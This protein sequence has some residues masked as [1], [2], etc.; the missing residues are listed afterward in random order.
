MCNRSMEA[1]LK[2]S[3]NGSRIDSDRRAKTMA[4]GRQLQLNVDIAHRQSSLKECVRCG[5][6]LH[7]HAYIGV[8]GQC[9]PLTIVLQAGVRILQKQFRRVAMLNPQLKHCPVLFRFPPWTEL[10]NAYFLPFPQGRKVDSSAHIIP[11][12]ELNSVDRVGYWQHL[13]K[14][15]CSPFKFLVSRIHENSVNSLANFFVQVPTD[16]CKPASS[17]IARQALGVLLR[18]LQCQALLIVCNGVHVCRESSL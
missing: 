2:A 11:M 6:L 12:S 15:C 7:L 16:S 4:R 17:G 3:Q 1:A 13:S 10:D 8:S 18:R 9:L 14:E 5:P